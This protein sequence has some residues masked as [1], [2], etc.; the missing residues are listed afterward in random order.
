M[1][2]NVPGQLDARREE[3]AALPA[4]QWQI[5]QVKRLSAGQAETNPSKPGGDGTN[6]LS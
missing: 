5:P 6:K 1:D 2:I 3:A 4:T